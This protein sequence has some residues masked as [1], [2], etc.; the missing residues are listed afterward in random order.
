[1]FY[2]SGLVIENAEVDENG[3]PLENPADVFSALFLLMFAAMR[4]G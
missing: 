1:M 3:L 4:A 2:F